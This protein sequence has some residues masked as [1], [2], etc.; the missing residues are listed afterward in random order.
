MVDDGDATRG[1]DGPSER[2]GTG[3]GM[4]VEEDRTPGL[5]ERRSA[6]DL[7]RVGEREL[8][9]NRRRR[10]SESAERERDQERFRDV[11]RVRDLPL[12]S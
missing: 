12:R 2:K 9:G 7:L 4:A 3:S 10:P 1:V 5:L 11:E 8:E 6:V